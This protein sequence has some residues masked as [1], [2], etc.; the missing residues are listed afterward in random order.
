MYPSTH[1]KRGMLRDTS[2]GSVGAN[3]IVSSWRIVFGIVSGGSC[4]ACV[5]FGSKKGLLMMSFPRSVRSSISIHHSA[6][7]NEPPNVRLR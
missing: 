5:C 1:P 2:V 7:L 4:V 3:E 6:G